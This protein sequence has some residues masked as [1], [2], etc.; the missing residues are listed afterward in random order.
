[1]MVSLPNTLTVI[2]VVWI[3]IL[4]IVCSCDSH[5]DKEDVACGLG[6]LMTVA[7]GGILLYRAVELLFSLIGG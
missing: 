5:S 3:V 7:S 4:L 2:S 6:L 1:M